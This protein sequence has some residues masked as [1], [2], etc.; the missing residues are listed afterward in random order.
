MA[1]NQ[2]PRTIAE[3]WRSFCTVAGSDKTPRFYEAFH[4]DDNEP[5]A[6]DLAELVLS[7]TKRATAGLLWAFE[8]TDK[9]PPAAGALS[10]V[11]YWNGTP[12]C[13]IETQSVEVVPFEEVTA[14][15]AS[16]EGE[17]DGSLEYWRRVHWASFSRECSRL[18]RQPSLAMPVICERFQVVYRAHT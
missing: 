15:F 1:A 12:V 8:H 11:T 10:I 13:I 6:N 2:V 5:S 17:G 18:G 16:T 14:E 7:G 4:F 3:F 9:K